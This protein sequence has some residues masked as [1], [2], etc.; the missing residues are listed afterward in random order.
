MG[1]AVKAKI[2]KR[3]RAHDARVRYLHREGEA[4]GEGAS[5]R[6][7]KTHTGRVCV[8]VG[9]CAYKKVAPRGIEPLF[10]L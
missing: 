1:E 3:R 5:G 4:S 6:K 10:T 7:E 2:E 8:A 9:E